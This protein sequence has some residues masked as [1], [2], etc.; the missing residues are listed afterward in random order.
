M[1]QLI[2]RQDLSFLL[3]DVLDVSELCRRP[4]FAEHS[5][6]VFDAV[7]DSSIKL[8]ERYFAPHN[9]KADEHEP[10]FDGQR[11]TMIP[12]VKEALTHYAQAGL[13]AARYDVELG[14]MQLPTVVHSASQAVFTA[15]NPSTVAYPFLTGAAANL[16]QAF[17]SEELKARFLPPMLDGRFFGTMAL[18]EPGVGSSLGDLRTAAEP[19]ADGTY[20]IKGQKMFISGGDQDISENIVHLVLARIKG[21]PIGVKGISLFLVPKFLIDTHGQSVRRNDVALAG[22]L[23]KMGYRGTTSTVLNFG[24]RD[25]CVGYLIGEAHQGLSYM[26]KMMNE[27]RI[28]VGLGAAAIGY[29]GYLESLAY[30]RERPQGRLPS[31]RDASSPPAMLI[32][33]AD[34]RRMLLAQKA[35][36]QG[37]KRAV[38]D[39]GVNKYH[40]RV[41]SA[42]EAAKAAGLQ[43]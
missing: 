37:I 16:I 32:E 41:K 5:R 9:A 36:Q 29:R 4:R 25:D 40:G 11:V 17:A 18:T 19:A 24:E 26:F 14:G 15:A 7:I 13:I 3:Y 39:R 42:A 12:E 6:E 38:F 20:R 10:S 22:L 23:H 34:I 31:N 21:A 27:A 2:D 43:I 28:G 30:A 33:H 8:A 35:F 1:A